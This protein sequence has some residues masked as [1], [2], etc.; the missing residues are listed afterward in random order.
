MEKVRGTVLAVLF[1]LGATGAEA[2]TIK[3]LQGA[4]AMEGTK[5]EEIFRKVGKKLEFKDRVASTS[6]GLL[7]SGN[8]VAGPMAVCTI[9]NIIRKKSTHLSAQL[10]CQTTMIIEEVSMSFDL[11]NP[12]KLKRFNPLGDDMYV[13]YRKCSM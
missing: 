5:C 2:A 4:W 1:V 10:S 6:T 11:P 13:D 9:T 3:D 8:K 7:F 12:S